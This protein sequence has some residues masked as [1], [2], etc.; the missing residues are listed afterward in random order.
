LDGGTDPV[1]NGP[2]WNN[3]LHSIRLY[4]SRL[5]HIFPSRLVH[6]SQ[7]SVQEFWPT[8]PKKGRLGEFGAELKCRE[9]PSFVKKPRLLSGYI[10]RPMAADDDAFNLSIKEQRGYKRIQ[11]VT[12]RGSGACR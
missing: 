7:L 1:Y 9:S 12:W 8:Q 3:R 10:M 2:D 4:M 5:G 6:G 11:T